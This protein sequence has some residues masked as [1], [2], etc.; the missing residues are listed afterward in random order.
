[1][2]KFFVACTPRGKQRAR[3]TH[4][5]TYTP[6]ETVELER[7]IGW[8]CKK[9]MAGMKPL[10]GPVSL[11]FVANFVH[12]KSWPQKKKDA[13]Y[14]HIVKPDLDNIEKLIKDALKNI[15][16]IDDCQ[17]SY[18]QKFK[19]YDELAGLSIEIDSIADYNFKPLSGY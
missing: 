5:G 14:W 7:M 12:P 18:V 8:E 6:H 19:Q 11:D 4:H 3:V 17:V 15:A 1:M 16:W 9:A 13:T 10:E 2:I